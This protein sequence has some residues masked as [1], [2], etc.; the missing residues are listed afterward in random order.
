M[1]HRALLMIR[2]IKLEYLFDSHMKLSNKSLLQLAWLL[3]GAYV[4]IISTGILQNVRK[5]YDH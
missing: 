5:D 4:A 2:T 3:H 1:L